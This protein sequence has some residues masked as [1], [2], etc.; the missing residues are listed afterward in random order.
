[1]GLSF[2]DVVFF[3]LILIRNLNSLSVDTMSFGI[4]VGVGE[5]ITL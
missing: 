2:I 4:R 3:L 5:V 1:M